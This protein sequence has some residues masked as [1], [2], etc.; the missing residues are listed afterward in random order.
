MSLCHARPS[1]PQISSAAIVALCSLV[2][3]QNHLSR[4][5]GRVGREF[6]KNPLK[7]RGEDRGAVSELR[8]IDVGNARLSVACEIDGYYGRMWRECW[9]GQAASC[10]EGGAVVGLVTRCARY[11]V[12]LRWGWVFLADGVVACRP[13]AGSRQ[14]SSPEGPRRLCGSVSAAN[15]ARRREAADGKAGKRLRVALNLVGSACLR[16]VGTFA[17]PARSTS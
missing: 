8:S 11:G 14:G 13:K 9:P 4:A 16:R 3:G 12:G 1:T 17:R 10:G 7:L 5:G 2:G 15:R 6:R